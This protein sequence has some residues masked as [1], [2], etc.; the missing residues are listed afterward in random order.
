MLTYINRVEATA[1]TLLR[2][3]GARP[4]VTLSP[5]QSAGKQ[6]D[7]AGE[8]AGR[9]VCLGV[10]GASISSATGG[11]DAVRR[12]LLLLRCLPE[13]AAVLS[14]AVSE[15]LRTCSEEKMMS[16]GPIPLS[17]SVIVSVFAVTRTVTPSTSSSW[18]S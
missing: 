16:R 9:L 15:A 6:T 8:V 17:N 4:V 10:E 12:R 2:L 5:Q 7:L 13:V 14:L 3:L 18:I 1:L 11:G